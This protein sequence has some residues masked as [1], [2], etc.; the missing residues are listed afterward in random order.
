MRVPHPCALSKVGNHGRVNPG[1][2]ARCPHPFA[3]FAKEWETGTRRKLR[4]PGC[5]RPE[6]PPFEKRK[7]WANRPSD[8]RPV[9]TRTP[10]PVLRLLAHDVHPSVRF[11][12]TRQPRDNRGKL[13]EYLVPALELTAILR[14]LHGLISNVGEFRPAVSQVLKEGHVVRAL[15]RLMFDPQLRGI[16][17]VSL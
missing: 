6:Y 11:L 14:A 15:D 5:M 4:G 1:A 13:L 9:L 12:F 8:E 2:C 10:P 7:G 16:N 3:Q 17:L